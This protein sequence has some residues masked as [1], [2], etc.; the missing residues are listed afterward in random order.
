MSDYRLKYF[1][2]IHLTT[3]LD[4]NEFDLLVDIMDD[5]FDA[6]FKYLNDIINKTK[7]I[8]LIYDSIDKTDIVKSYESL[9][10]EYKIYN[11][12]KKKYIYNLLENLDDSNLLKIKNFIPKERI[13]DRNFISK[14]SKKRNKI[15]K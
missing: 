14:E 12:N 15:I 3:G 13:K 2:N 10:K 1:S 11:K 6:W 7:S 8:E 4:E 5:N 9:E